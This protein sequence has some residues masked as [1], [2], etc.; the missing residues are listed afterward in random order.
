MSNHRTTH[1]AR[2][3]T[4]SKVKPT[5]SSNQSTTGQTN[6]HRT[7]VSNQY[8]KGLHHLTIQHYHASIENHTF[9]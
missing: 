7:K 4:Y 9:T 6:N 2:L 3:G 5:L 8:H 1:L